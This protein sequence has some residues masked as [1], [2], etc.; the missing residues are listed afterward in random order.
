MSGLFNTLLKTNET[1]WNRYIQHSFIRQLGDGSL[2]RASFEHY[3]KQD[4]V[5]LVHFARAFGL[6]AFKS[7]SIKELQHAKAMMAGIMDV[8]LGLHVQYCQEWGISQEVLDGITES[9]ANMAYTRYV[10]ERGLAGDLLDLNVAL[11]PCIVGY[12]ETAKWLSTQA[13]LKTDDN[14]YLPWLEMYASDEYQEVANAH[15]AML[16]ETDVLTLSSQRLQALNVNFGSATRLEVDFWQM[17]LD[18]T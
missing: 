8:E 7:S 5:F 10:M 9:T 14:P 4:Y 12:A 11:A 18:I 2:S 15:R 13:F 17:G 6:A 16:D 1:D 3:L